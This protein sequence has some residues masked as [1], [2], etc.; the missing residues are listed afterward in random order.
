M[1]MTSGGPYSS[2]RVSVT[3]PCRHV[4]SSVLL[5]SRL[6]DVGD[7]F[8]TWGVSPETPTAARFQSN[9][10]T[11]GLGVKLGGSFQPPKALAP[12]FFYC[13]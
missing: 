12:L 3:L 8:G 9:V 2:Q 5:S 13:P 1:D 6:Q 4:C 7:P 10:E 11:L